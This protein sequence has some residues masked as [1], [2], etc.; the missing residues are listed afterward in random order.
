MRKLLENGTVQ[1]H[2]LHASER[3]IINVDASDDDLYE[4]TVA[5]VDSTHDGMIEGV[6]DK[7]EINERGKDSFV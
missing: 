1:L 4:S 7:L 5:S 3:N 2:E 6:E